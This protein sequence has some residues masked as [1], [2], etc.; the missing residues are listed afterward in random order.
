[1][2]GLGKITLAQLAYKHEKILNHFDKKIWVCVSNPFDAMKVAKAVI[3]E[4]EGNTPNIDDLESLVQ[5][6]CKCIEGKKFLLILDDVWTDD[7]RKWEN[8]KQPLQ[9]G[10]RGSKI[11]MTTRKEK[12]A[13]MMG[14]SSSTISVDVLSEEHSWVIFKQHAFLERREE[15][16]KHLE[17][18]GRNIARRSNGLPLVAKSLGSL[19]CFKRTRS[20]WVDC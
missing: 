7:K 17:E 13:I 3:V 18:I 10:A 5:K 12:V 19:I 9:Y 6:I 1:M 4:I 15:K 20:Q 14:V 8:L 11:L 16:L 2:G